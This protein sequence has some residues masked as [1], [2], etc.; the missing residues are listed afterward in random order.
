MQLWKGWANAEKTCIYRAHCDKNV[1]SHPFQTIV[2]ACITTSWNFLRLSD[3]M[4][5]P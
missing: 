2:L 3:P 4:S 5:N 1:H